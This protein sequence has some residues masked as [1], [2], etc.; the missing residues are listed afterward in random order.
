MLVFTDPCLS[1]LAGAHITEEGAAS[2]PHAAMRSL[3]VVTAMMRPR[4]TLL[5]VISVFLLTFA[6]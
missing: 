2:G 3:T 6:L 4:Y 5:I 1:T